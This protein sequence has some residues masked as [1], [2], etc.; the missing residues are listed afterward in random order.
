[1]PTTIGRANEY[2]GDYHS[3][4]FAI[5]VM[6]RSDRGLYHLAGIRNGT[7]TIRVPYTALATTLQSIQRMGGRIAT[8]TPLFSSGAAATTRP[9]AVPT[10]QA[11]TLAPPQ[12]K[13]APSVAPSPK[14]TPVAAQRPKA[15]SARKNTKSKRR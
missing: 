11:E 5:T 12:P 9:E 2:I 7:Y 15:S 14:A 6:R 13:A 4:T 8:V 3:R 1:M 10:P